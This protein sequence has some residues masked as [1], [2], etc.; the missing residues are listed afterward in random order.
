MA[1]VELKQVCKQVDGK[2]A[3]REVSWHSRHPVVGVLGC[4]GAGKTTLLRLLAGKTEADGGQVALFGL[5]LAEHRADI[6]G[7]VALMSAQGTHCGALTVREALLLAAS[8]CG[9]SPAQAEAAA[10]EVL[11]FFDLG[12]HAG[13]RLAALGRGLL[14]RSRLAEAVVARPRLLLVDDPAALLAARERAHLLCLLTEVPARFHCSLILASRHLADIERVCA[15]VMV[16]AEGKVLYSGAVASLVAPEEGLY[17]VHIQGDRQDFATALHAQGCVFTDNTTHFEV[18]LPRG[19]CA[20]SLFAVA[21]RAQVQVR[22]IA[23]MTRTLTRAFV[24][25]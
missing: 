2:P 4:A 8:G 23:P 6:A 14:Q 22:H 12:A 25:C 17:A 16:L 21:A 19:A 1:Q 20:D 9:M 11:E 18:R 3:L 13:R 10:V 15:Q 7:R 24:P 5:N